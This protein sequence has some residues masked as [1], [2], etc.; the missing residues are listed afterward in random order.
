MYEDI[1]GNDRALRSCMS[2]ETIMMNSGH[3]NIWAASWQNQQNDLCA[4]RRLGSAWASA[5]YDQSLRCP[6]EETLVSQLPIHH[7]A[8]TDQTGWMPRLIWV[9][10]RRTYHFVGFVMLLLILLLK[11]L[12]RHACS[13]VTDLCKWPMGNCSQ[14]T[15]PAYC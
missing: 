11:S 4:Q 13:Q 9:F 5:Q 1:K 12:A 10:A 15:F 8:E 3:S 6:H 14:L 7:T 2:L